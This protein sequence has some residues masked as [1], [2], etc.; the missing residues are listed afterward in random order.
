MRITRITYKRVVNI[1]NY[2]SMALEATA[3]INVDETDAD[4]FYNLQA[5]VHTQLDVRDTHCSR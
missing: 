5:W 3:D 2:E 4:V 1:G